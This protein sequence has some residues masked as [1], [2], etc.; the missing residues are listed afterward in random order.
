MLV[1]S[2]HENLSCE[3][4][5]ARPTRRDQRANLIEDLFSVYFARAH[6]RAD[7]SVDA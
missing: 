3:H 5:R 4:K 6:R 7:V 2:A 1:L